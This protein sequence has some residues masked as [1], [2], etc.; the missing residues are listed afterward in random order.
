M[1]LALTNS[2][3]RLIGTMSSKPPTPTRQTVPP[4]RAALMDRA[5]C[6]SDG[7]LEAQWSGV[8]ERLVLVF[9]EYDPDGV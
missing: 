2:S 1:R 9:R 5:I 4:V 6:L 7:D 3:S 8:R